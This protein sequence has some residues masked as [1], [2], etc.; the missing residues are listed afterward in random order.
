MQD[1]SGKGTV[2]RDD[3][4]RKVF[5]V[6]RPGETRADFIQSLFEFA[7]QTRSYKVTLH[8]SRPGEYEQDTLT[9]FVDKFKE[10][11]SPCIIVFVSPSSGFTPE[12]ID[13]LVDGCVQS[14][15]S[16]VY[17]LPVPVG[18][19]SFQG[20]EF[21]YSCDHARIMR[22][23]FHISAM[24]NR[25][26]L[27][28]DS[29]AQVRTF[30]RDDIVAIPYEV[31]TK[32]LDISRGYESLGAEFECRVYTRYTTSNGGISSCFFEQLRHIAD[33]RAGLHK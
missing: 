14:S 29:S 12:S 2:T 26:H 20:K 10:F 28:K 27:D 13:V 17:G 25:I 9:M 23:K 5:L 24:D 22:A 18:P 32:N 15:G 6:V 31:A 30:Q 33:M 1:Q 19:S 21:V 16:K 3:G 8:V 4:A 7:S 11:A